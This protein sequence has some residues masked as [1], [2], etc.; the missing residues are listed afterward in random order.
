LFL[1]QWHQQHPDRFSRITVAGRRQALTKGRRGIGS[2]ERLAGT[3]EADETFVGGNERNKHA[4]KKLGQGRGT[5]GK[6]V[7]MG[8]LE[9]GE[10]SAV[11][12]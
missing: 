5:V 9:R 2:F 4:N 8:V 6:A 11:R 12:A 1:W 7:I 3:V 10:T